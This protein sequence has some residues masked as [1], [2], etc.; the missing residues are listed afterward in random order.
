M[1]VLI[2][3]DAVQPYLGPSRRV[4][5]YRLCVGISLLMLMLIV[6]VEVLL[7]LVA[8][9]EVEVEVAVVMVVDWDCGDMVFFKN[10]KILVFFAV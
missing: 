8:E 5:L 7:L 1:F 10:N 9:V 6:E 3:E 2:P 4:R